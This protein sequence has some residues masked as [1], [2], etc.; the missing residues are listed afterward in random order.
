MSQNRPIVGVGAL[1]LTVPLGC[2][3]IPSG[4][5]ATT[6]TVMSAHVQTLAGLAGWST[7]ALAVSAG[8]GIGM[9]FPGCCALGAFASSTTTRCPSGPSGIAAGGLELS[10]E[11]PVMHNFH[12]AARVGRAGTRPSSQG[13]FLS[14]YLAGLSLALR[15]PKEQDAVSVGAGQSRLDVVLSYERW[16]LERY[17]PAGPADD[18]GGGAILLGVRFGGGYGL[19]L[20]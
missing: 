1:A 11:I 13:A 17:T 5:P 18:F 12:F 19:N 8:A 10:A 15:V 16:Q 20:R 9:E 2:G 14:G 7:E 3:A 4:P 6:D